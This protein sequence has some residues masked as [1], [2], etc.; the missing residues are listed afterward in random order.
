VFLAVIRKEFV[1]EDMVPGPYA[2]KC[3][4][5][6]GRADIRAF[7]V[8][9]KSDEVKFAVSRQPGTP[10]P[11]ALVEEKSIPLPPSDRLPTVKK[12]QV[13]VPT[14]DSSFFDGEELN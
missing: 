6:W 2:F 8:W 12:L 1:G 7:P 9:R 5:A 10:E 3:N 4:C 14:D 13:I 11:K